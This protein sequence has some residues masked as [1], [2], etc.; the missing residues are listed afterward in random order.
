MKH[1][2]ITQ[3]NVLTDNSTRPSLIALDGTGNVVLHVFDPKSDQP[4][5]A[6][7][8]MTAE[9]CR[10]VGVMLIEK[11]YE[12]ECNRQRAVDEREER[13]VMREAMT[14]TATVDR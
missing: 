6:S 10:A 9:Y 11:A 12:A 3:L 5:M 14:S 1:P 13:A 2:M 7:F 8:D 4:M